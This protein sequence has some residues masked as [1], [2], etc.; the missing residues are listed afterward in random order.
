MHGH[1]WVCA[2]CMQ[3]VPGSQGCALRLAGARPG[4]SSVQPGPSQPQQQLAQAK[5]HAHT[6][7]AHSPIRHSG[8]A[9]YNSNTK[10]WL[11]A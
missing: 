9:F 6:I 2:L 1:A 11:P 3:Q 4:M 5:G 7:H 10:L 8:I